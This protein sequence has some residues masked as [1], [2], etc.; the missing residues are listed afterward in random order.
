MFLIE[1]THKT[2]VARSRIYINYLYYE[3]EIM[4]MLSALLYRF[5]SQR[6]NLDIYES[7]IFIYLLVYMFIILLVS[8]DGL[9]TNSFI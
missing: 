2:T 1:Y 5:C 8:L 7:I 9:I 6:I 3:Y 4:G